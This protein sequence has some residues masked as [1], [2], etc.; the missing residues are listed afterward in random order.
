[1]ILATT[2]WMKRD[3]DDD[4]GIG[5]SC[6]C[7]DISAA[8]LG[9]KWVKADQRIRLTAHTNYA[10]GRAEVVITPCTWGHNDC[11][12]VA[13]VCEAYIQVPQATTKLARWLKAKNVEE[14]TIYVEV[15]VER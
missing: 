11:V 5:N 2:G 12:H 1:M 15:E 13:R 10:A 8:V 6:I 9:L 3:D 14:A 4:F 7:K